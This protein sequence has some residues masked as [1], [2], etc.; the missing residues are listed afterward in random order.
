VGMGGAAA[1]PELK[2]ADPK[3]VVDLFNRLH[4]ANLAVRERRFA[5]ALPLLQ[6][7]LRE[8]PGNTEVLLRLGNANLGL[9]RFRE[10]RDFFRAFAERTPKSAVAHHWIAV[11]SL[12]LGETDLALREADAAVALDPGLAEARAIK[13]ALLSASGDFEGAIRELRAAVAADPGKAAPRVSLARALAA[14]GRRAEAEEEYE[15]VV[16]RYPDDAD[17]LTGLGVLVA[18]RGDPIRAEELLRRAL[19]SRPADPAAFFDLAL[20]LEQ[21][22]RRS[23]A[24][25]AYRRLSRDPSAPPAIRLASQR[26]LASLG[27]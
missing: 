5:D 4:R 3:D 16:A 13:G 25:E 11:C 27:L 24:T 18:G 17:A 8:H 23:E 2:G 22:G 12:R 15:A 21:Q 9:G 1:A 20:V 26:R 10:A 14:R 6:E 19:A 7:I